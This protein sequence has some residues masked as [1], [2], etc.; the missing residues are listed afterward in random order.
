MILSNETKVQLC[1]KLSLPYSGSEQDWDVELADKNR[2]DEF[3]SYYQENEL[4]IEMKYAVMSIILAS[5]DDYLNENVL[6]RDNR[7]YEIGKLLKSEKE[8][9]VDLINYWAVDYEIEDFFRITPLIREVN[10]ID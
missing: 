3:I 5:Y 6:D 2:V 1:K 8:A 10:A 9:F 7:W 4:P